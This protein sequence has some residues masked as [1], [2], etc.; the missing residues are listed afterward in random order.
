MLGA[1]SPSSSSSSSSSASSSSSK[2]S[3]F[4]SSDTVTATNTAGTS[5]SATTL[6]TSTTPISSPTTPTPTGPSAKTAVG[7]YR[8]QGC[9]TEATN[10]R[11]LTGKSYF[12]AEY[13]RECYCGD[14][15]RGGSV[16]AEDQRDCSANGFRKVS[17]LGKKEGD[18]SDA[19]V[20]LSG[21][22]RAALPDR[23]RQIKCDLVRGREG[24]FVDGWSRLLR[25]LRT[26]NELIGHQGSAIIPRV[27][28]DDL[29]SGCEK[30]KDEIMKRGVVVVRGVV[31]EEEARGYKFELDEY[32]AR[33]P[34]TRA[35]P[36]HDPQVYELYW[37]GPQ[38]KAR[39]HPSLLRVQRQLM[40]HFWHAAEETVISLANPLTYADRLR[41]RKPG[42]ESFALGPHMDG[43]SV[44]RWEPEGYGRGGVYDKILSGHWESHEPWDAGGR[45]QAVN[46]LYDGLGAC[47][48]FRAWQGWLA[49][50]DSGP[51]Q[52]TL[53]VNP[54]MRLVTAY[55]LMRP[56]FRPLNEDRGSDRFLEEGNWA[57]TGGGEMTSELQGAVPGFGQEVSDEL[58][59]HLQLERTMVH[60][61]AV[62]AGDFVAWHCDIDKVHAGTSDSS[63]LYIPVCP[64]TVLNGEYLLRQRAAFRNGTPAPDFPGGE[65]EA[66]HVGRPSEEDMSCRPWSSAEGREAFG[67]ERLSLRDGAGVGEREAVGRVNALLGL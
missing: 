34:H 36:A 12:G 22:Q 46:N 2:G 39:V 5:S 29:D 63:V 65:G 7:R 66:R 30:V 13:G 18:I 11:A 17:S 33:N 4:S 31:P 25:R 49:M 61:P 59:P 15:L 3:S 51:R 43:G 9:W 64:T 23:F 6:P 8:F 56:F 57:F 55:V 40:G 52:G 32:I 42:D 26:E 35:F 21:T 1:Q 38:L 50:S 53:L 37:S 10:G 44:E 20:S 45:V 58:H 48:M 27:D 24:K 62:K 19:F 28:F 67:L 47:S 54:L 14:G 41:I 60:I 16:R